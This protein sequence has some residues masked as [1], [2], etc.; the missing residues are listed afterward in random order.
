[1][2]YGLDVHKTF[3]QVCEVDLDGKRLREFRVGASAS[4]IEAFA[5]T[6]KKSDLV[7]LEATFHT[8]AI[9]DIL[10]RYA[11]QVVVANP[12][13]VKAI[14][15]A[16]IKSDKVDAHILAQLLRMGFLP[17]VSMPDADT[18][19]LRQLVSHRRHLVKHRVALKNT[20]QAL[21]NR[22]LQHFTGPS[23]FT[24][25][26]RAWLAA[27][28]LEPAECFMLDNA[29]QLLDA[30]NLSLGAVD[31]ELASRAAV[32]EKVKLLMTIPGIDITV[33]VGLVAAIGDV[34]RF[35]SPG[36]LATYF[37]LVPRMSQ[38]AARCYHGRIT[39]SGNSTARHLAIEASQVLARSASPLTAT[40][41]RLRRK[42]GHN[43][44]V[45]ALAR[46]LIVLIWHML[47]K[48]QPYR[49]AALQTTQR[50]LR[51]ITRPR[52]SAACA[53]APTSLDVV[54]SEAH[55]P[56]LKPASS[57]ERQ[58]AARNRRTVTRLRTL[59]AQGS[60]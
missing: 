58:A 46:K 2:L 41:H 47:S 4:E 36:K 60:V 18:W 21:L 45:T 57:A 3:I 24:R 6:L 35:D 25:K 8:W 15:H 44:A 1:M 28:E 33:A 38:S 49:Y 59:R 9:H 50:K 22:R 39:K 27:L 16:R 43:V 42:R 40:Y 51:A 26:G 10:R 13:E 19:E 32:R 7:A 17:E 54:Y 5:R 37:G 20:I 29:L 14:A 23:I 31:T 11:G 30:T 34:E 48:N 52:T 56:P 53:S 55:L 12:L